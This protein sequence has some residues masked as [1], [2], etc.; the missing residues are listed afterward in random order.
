MPW[1]EINDYGFYGQ[2]SSWPIRRLHWLLAAQTGV[3]T[4]ILHIYQ[5]YCFLITNV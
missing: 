3:Q 4:C 2:G 5:K 1:H